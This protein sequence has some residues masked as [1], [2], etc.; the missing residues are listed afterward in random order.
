MIRLIDISSGQE[1]KGAKVRWCVVKGL[2]ASC[3][4]ADG[5]IKGR[6]LPK[7]DTDKPGASDAWVH[8]K[9]HGVASAIAAASSEHDQ[10]FVLDRESGWWWPAE[11]RGT[12]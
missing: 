7:V 4:V 2:S 1:I 10:I 9:G 6:A 11:K 3:D 5:V 8:K 12:E